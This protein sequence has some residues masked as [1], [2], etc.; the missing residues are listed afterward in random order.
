M[1]YQVGSVGRVIVARFN[2]GDDILGGLQEIA[3]RENLRSAAFHLVG[4]IRGGRYVV[5]PETEEL[6]PVPMWRELT[7]SHEAVGFGTIF[8]LG[9][10]PKVHFHGSY[11]KRDTVRGGC[12]REASET[13]LVLEAVIQE[14]VG[15]DAVRE[16]DPGSGMALLQLAGGTVL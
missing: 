9:D 5:G 14:L 15:I 4:G 2:D 8:W 6:P 12:L 3:R 16:T 7:E 10:T 1:I 13:F 11:A